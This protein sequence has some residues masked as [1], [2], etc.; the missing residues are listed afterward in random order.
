[1]K[2]S[3]LTLDQVKEYLRVD[4]DLD[5]NRIKT[6]ISTVVYFILQ[7]NGQSKLTDEFEGRNEFLTDVALSM[8]QELYDTGKFPESRY[9]YQA[10]TIDRRF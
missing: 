10:M 8:I 9:L 7:M 4:H 5:D 1:M 2:L 6:H 3:E